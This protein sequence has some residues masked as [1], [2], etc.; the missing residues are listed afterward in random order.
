ML[1]PDGISVYQE[2]ASFFDSHED[3]WKCLT[4]DFLKPQ[5]AIM[6][7]RDQ[8]SL[9]FPSTPGFPSRNQTPLGWNI[10]LCP[11]MIK[12]I[13]IIYIFDKAM[14]L[15]TIISPLI[16]LF[17]TQVPGWIWIRA[18]LR[19]LWEASDLEFCLYYD[20]P[21]VCDFLQT[22]GQPQSRRSLSCCLFPFSTS[23]L[24]ILFYNNTK[25]LLIAPVVDRIII[26]SISHQ[27]VHVL[28]PGTWEYVRLPIKGNRSCR[29]N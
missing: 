22:Q 13:E 20:S 16:L 11:K 18:L 8:R 5:R 24:R 25:V 21:S 19:G 27:N 23:C 12:W 3:P 26:P 28:I 7:W 1:A 9:T 4:I 2:R 15:S 29:G 17:K 10:V 14:I 6:I